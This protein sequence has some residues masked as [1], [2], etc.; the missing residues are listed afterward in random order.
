MVYVLFQQC[1]TNILLHYKIIVVGFVVFA[2]SIVCQ[3]EEDE[4]DT[5]PGVATSNV[6]IILSHNNPCFRCNIAIIN[7]LVSYTLHSTHVY[8]MMSSYT[9]I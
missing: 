8:I 5:S 3:P 9:K 1:S 6:R 4:M 2:G 7:F